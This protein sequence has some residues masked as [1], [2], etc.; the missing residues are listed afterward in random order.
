M[1]TAVAMCTYNGE[2]YLS[3][4]L[5]SILCQNPL[6]DQI[7]VYDDGS[8]D[9][10]WEI[11]LRYRTKHPDLFTLLR[12][13]RHRG[14]NGGMGFLLSRA[15]A[16]AVF[17][18]DQDDIWMPG[19]IK[20]LLEMADVRPDWHTTPY[21]IHSEARIIPGKP[22]RRLMS[23][24][25]GA[26]RDAPQLEDLFC[27][28]LVQGCTMLVN[29]P[30]LR[31]ISAAVLSRL[32]HCIYDQWMALTATAFGCVLFCPAP[33]VEYRIHGENTVGTL[34]IDRHEKNGL[35]RNR[36]IACEFLFRYG[37]LLPDHARRRIRY[38]IRTGHR[39]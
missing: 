31:M 8:G 15:D 1:K 9:S 38:W 23:D 25:I 7:Y 35:S 11:L 24:L 5:D 17:L 18:C 2:K 16:D 22:K 3:D 4:Q 36:K 26:R 28:N 34:I 13:G 10:T 20:T 29:R 30:L 27:H 6:P 12:D 33:L 37:A 32:T 39:Q 19:K 21:I 14:I